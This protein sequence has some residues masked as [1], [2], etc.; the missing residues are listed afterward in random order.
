MKY[1]KTFENE[2]YTGDDIKHHIPATYQNE[3]KEYTNNVLINIP[4]TQYFKSAI[5]FQII[6]VDNVYTNNNWYRVISEDVIKVNS[7][8]SI[9]YPNSSWIWDQLYNEDDFERQ[10][11]MTVEEFYNQYTDI[12]IGLLEDAIEKN[13]ITAYSNSYKV[14][15][16]SVI[17]KMTIPQTEHIVNANVYNL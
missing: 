10:N 11:F 9:N 16:E 1:I 4:S 14:G 6:F 2:P 13:K 15:I 7:D 5:R 17:R 3:L 12:F 8:D